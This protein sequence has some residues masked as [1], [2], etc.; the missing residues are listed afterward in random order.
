MKWIVVG[1]AVAMAVVAYLDM[2]ALR[3]PR[4]VKERWFFWSVW[5]LATVMAVLV[6]LDVRLPN[7]LE[8]I[9]AVF[10]PIGHVVDHW[11]E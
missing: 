3:G 5:S 6:A 10:Q 2:Q 4:M 9:D 1:T 8:G 11:L 7:P